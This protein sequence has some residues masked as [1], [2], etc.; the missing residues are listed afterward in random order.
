MLYKDH[1]TT[2]PKLQM[3]SPL[4]SSSMRCGGAWASCC[5]Y[6]TELSSF[7]LC[8]TCYIPNVPS[9]ISIFPTVQVRTCNSRNNPSNPHISI[10]PTYASHFVV[11]IVHIGVYL[12]LTLWL[13]NCIPLFGVYKSQEQMLIFQHL[14]GSCILC[15]RC[16]VGIVQWKLSTRALP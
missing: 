5:H 1:K 2:L 12:F 11:D 6:S 3:W 13:T 15:N 16:S 10:N 14:T 7:Q 9:R 4:Q 8:S